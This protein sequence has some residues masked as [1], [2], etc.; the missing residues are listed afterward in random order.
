MPG[1]THDPNETEYDLTRLVEILAAMDGGAWSDAG[2]GPDLAGSDRFRL[3]SYHDRG[4]QGEIWVALDTEL[5]REVAVKILKQEH[6]DNRAVRT[7]FEREAELTGA[8]EHRGIVPVYGLGRCRDG[9]PYYAMRLIRGSTLQQVIVEF[10]RVEAGL[11]QGERLLR[12]RRLLGSF[13]DACNTVAF[14]HTRRILHRDLKP[15][16]IFVDEY[17]ETLVVD[18]G[19]AKATVDD[20]ESTVVEDSGPESVQAGFLPITRPGSRL[21]TPEY[22]SPE[23]AAGRTEELG[24]ETDVY[25]LGATLYCLLTGKPPFQEADRS[26]TYAKVCAGDFL[27]PRQAQPGVP[28]ALEAVC[29]KA[30]ALDPRNRYPTPRLLAEDVERWLADQPVQAYPEPWPTRVLRWTRRHRRGVSMAAGAILLGTIGLAIH[31]WTITRERNKLALTHDTLRDF[32]EVAGRNLA[33]IPDT[34]SLRE[35]LAVRLLDRYREMSERFGT[36][37]GDRLEIAQ[38]YRVLGGI[39]RLTGQFSKSRDYYEKAIKELS[40]LVERDPARED[41]SRWL[42]ETLIDRGELNHMHNRTSD[43]ERDFRRAIDRLEQLTAGLR[44]VTPEY[45]AAR[46]SALINLS[47]VLLVQRR[48]A[49]AHKAADT[50][51]GLITP[52][53]DTTHDSPDT[54]RYRWLLAMAL[55]DRGAASKEAGDR[56][57]ARLD[58]DSASRIAGQ[59]TADDDYYNDAQFQLASIANQRGDLL[60]GDQAT[61]AESE[62][63]YDEAARILSGL[64]KKHP[65]RPH[66]REELAVTYS[67]RAAVRQAMGHL[68]EAQ[69]DCQAA[70]EQLERLIA[71]EG[72]EEARDNAG[73]RCLLGQVYARQGRI[74]VLQGHKSEGKKKLALAIEQLRRALQLDSVRATDRVILD[75]LEAE[76][77]RM[78]R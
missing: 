8:L 78:E 71:E 41:C 15:G 51:V 17:G 33:A 10:Q 7:R 61:I 18:W 54:S 53:L 43:A 34:E 19:L 47:E 24:P 1:T 73:Y 60:I 44:G 55:M 57:R 65:Q 21:G 23:Q 4:G 77:A 28:P 20:T 40:D 16:N 9:R 37:P 67:G 76:A 72:H 29:L 68:L 12:L 63:N 35:F 38:I 56:G 30:M 14:A 70:L 75:E 58:F 11:A 27:R 25:S 2:A 59:I 32:L 6:V 3:L 48:L 5:N 42:A 26:V 52:L 22:M 46:A 45:S 66:F 62:R 64:M 50:A 74:L 39:E 31:D 49:E 36:E 13:V 69:R